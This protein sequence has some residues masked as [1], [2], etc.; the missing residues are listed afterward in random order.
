MAGWRVKAPSGSF[1]NRNS[2]KGG[3]LPRV[4]F[5]SASVT[6]KDS[7]FGIMSLDG[8]AKVEPLAGQPGDSEVS[9]NLYQ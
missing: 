5:T 7:R 3:I 2:T 8:P 4:R 1:S 6:A 9:D